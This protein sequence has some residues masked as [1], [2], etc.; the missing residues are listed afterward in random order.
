MTF[1]VCYWDEVEGVQKERDSTPEEDTQ[2]DA[3]I[4]EHNARFP[5]EVTALQGLLAISQSGL[6]NAYEAWAADPARTFAEKAFIS[7]AMTWRYDDP[8]LSAGCVT[9]GISDEQ[10]KQLFILAASL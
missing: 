8:I 4:A 1:K 5:Q 7:R 6:A 10:K 3:D 9:L 2:R